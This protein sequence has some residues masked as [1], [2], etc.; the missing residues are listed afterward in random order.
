[1]EI[2]PSHSAVFGCRLGIMNAEKTQSD[3]Y[4]I[5]LLTPQSVRYAPVVQHEREL[6]LK[7][8]KES[9]CFPSLEKKH[10]PY[11]LSVGLEKNALS[12]T[13]ASVEGDMS[14]VVSL[15][16]RSLKSF[17]KDY[18]LIVESYEQAKY[19]GGARLESIDMA[20][21]GV[22][23]EAADF[24]RQ[25]LSSRLEMNEDTARALFTLICVLHIGQV[26]GPR[27]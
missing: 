26:R 13:F 19:A 7:A 25:R 3:I 6:A 12:L 11:N 17:I 10:T 9:G 2:T 21:R 16:L 22:H 23:N 8:L 18:F 20:R 5:T 27:I 4:E 1:M 14:K 24:L 15:P